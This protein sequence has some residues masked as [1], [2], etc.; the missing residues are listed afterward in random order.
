VI[1]YFPLS[2]LLAVAVVGITA[3]MVLLVV[4]ARVVVVVL[5]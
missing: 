5:E 1:A 3:Q 2:L 4:L